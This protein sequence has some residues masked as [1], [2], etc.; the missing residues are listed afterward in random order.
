MELIVILGDT[1]IVRKPPVRA[2]ASSSLSSYMVSRSGK[3]H[4]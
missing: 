3:S 1:L 2:S 4:R